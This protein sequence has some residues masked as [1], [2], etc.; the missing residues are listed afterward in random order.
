MPLAIALH[1]LS[2]VVW[3]GGMFFAYMALRPAASVLD[4]ATRL[5]LWVRSFARFFPWVWLSVIVLPFTGYWMM[6]H[7]FGNFD[8]APLYI[9]LMQG[10]GVLMIL[11][12]LHVFFAPYARLKRGV[13]AAD[14]PLAAKALAQIRTL[15][16]LNLALGLVTVAIAGAGRYGVFIH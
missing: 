15:V 2:A 16:G 14:W 3:V 7:A 11:I 10:I 1:L 5:P 8:T 13:G 6:F 12:F 9:Q 4:P